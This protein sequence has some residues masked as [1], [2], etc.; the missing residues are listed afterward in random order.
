VNRRDRSAVNI[1]TYAAVKA[2]VLHFTS[3]IHEDL[4][5]FRPAK[6]SDVESRKIWRDVKHLSRGVGVATDAASSGRKDVT[7][8]WR[9]YGD[10]QFPRWRLAITADTEGRHQGQCARD[11]QS[12]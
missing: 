1:L 5:E 4:S 7:V 6:P 8:G 9:A 12:S 2:D 10:R 3:L 11:S